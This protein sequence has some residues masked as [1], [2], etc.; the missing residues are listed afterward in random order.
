[1]PRAASR[2]TRSPVRVYG[3]LFIDGAQTSGELYGRALAVI[4]A[5]QHAS[6]LVVPGTQRMPTTSWGSHKDL[7]TKALR[8]LAAPHLPASLSKLEQAV[9]RTHSAQPPQ[10]WVGNRPGDVAAAQRACTSTYDE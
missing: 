1:M 6:R 5:E 3:D 10:A 2:A 4:A 9:R 8:K 7:A